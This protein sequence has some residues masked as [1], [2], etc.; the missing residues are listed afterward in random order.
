MQDASFAARPDAIVGR[1]ALAPGPRALQDLSDGLKIKGWYARYDNATGKVWLAEAADDTRLGW[2]DEV[3]FFTY[4]GDDIDAMS[5]AFDATGR[6]VIAMERAGNLWVRYWSGSSYT[7]TDTGAGTSP[8]LVHQA[9]DSGIWRLLYLLYESGTDI[10]YRVASDDYAASSDTLSNLAANQ[11]VER[12]ILDD[13]QRVHLI[14]SNHVPSTGRYDPPSRI[15]SDYIPPC[16]DITGVFDRIDDGIQTVFV[17]VADGELLV[18]CAL[19]VDILLIGGGGDSGGGNGLPTTFWAS[20]GGVALNPAVDTAPAD[21]LADGGGGGAALDLDGFNGASGGGG[22]GQSPSGNSMFTVG[23]GG[24]AG[25][26]YAGGGGRSSW[27][28]LARK[29][30]G[31]GGGGGY[32]GPGIGSPGGKAGIGGP[33]GGVS[34]WNWSGPGGGRG[35]FIAVSGPSTG[36][37]TG[38]GGAGGVKSVLALSIQPNQAIAITVGGGSGGDPGGNAGAGGKAL[39]GPGYGGMAAIRVRTQAETTPAVLSGGTEIVD[40]GYRYHV[41]TANG[42]ITVSTPGTAEILVVGGGGGGGSD[43]GAGGGGGGVRI[44]TINL[45]TP[46]E[47]VVVGAGGA[48]GVGGAVGAD[49]GGSSLGGTIAAAYGGGGGAGDGTAAGNGA[50]G[51]GGH[52]DDGDPGPGRP[53]RG[54]PGGQGGGFSLTAG[55]D[56]KAA[57]GGGGVAGEGDEGAVLETQ[58]DEL[59]EDWDASSTFVVQIAEQRGT[60]TINTDRGLLS[61]NVSRGE[62]F[63]QG[64]GISGHNDA[65]VGIAAR[66]SHP[67]GV[68][69]APDGHYCFFRKTAGVFGLDGVE[70]GGVGI[71]L[72][73]WYTMQLYVADGVQQAFM[74]PS[75]GPDRRV[76]SSSTT[77]DGQNTRSAGVRSHGGSNGV[78][79]RTWDDNMVFRSKNLIVSGIPTGGKAQIR[80]AAD[81]LVAEATEVGGVATIDCSG[82]GD[83]ATGVAEDVPTVGWQTIKVLDVA[84]A[85]VD[86][87]T[88]GGIYPGDELEVVGGVLQY[89]DLGGGQLALGLVEWEDFSRLTP[90]PLNGDGGIGREIPAAWQAAAAGDGGFFGGGGGG[91][92]EIYLAGVGGS[93]GGG[94]GS[95][96]V[97]APTVGTDETGGGGGGSGDSATAGA[98]GGDGIVVIRTVIP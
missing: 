88:T 89:V 25:Q 71:S 36:A 13:S 66:A 50:T 63:V 4:T 16:M 96:D 65:Y 30:A 75:S 49:G 84:S 5:L 22:G 86:E 26:G 11:R 95:V 44:A 93:G 92:A 51:G 55:G 27:G 74:R 3:E 77:Y 32:G 43:C 87:I 45:V 23:G 29:D 64:A 8:V 35:Y 62:M 72:G 9:P 94:D 85:L 91:G 38:G 37:V 73:V 54:Y 79:R 61:K 90:G 15:S 56:S 10:L 34:G 53:L 33:G 57:A 14:L 82:F 76:S 1:V 47:A 46:S 18:A 58:G 78:G 28:L 12:G 80:N 42:T 20:A 69:A 52:G 68:D 19:D 7:L 39:F 70:V 98:D 97:A 67:S 59:A 81:G 40:S 41:F 6:P 21:H 31:S 17:L 83:G 2:M 48:G 24:I 60:E